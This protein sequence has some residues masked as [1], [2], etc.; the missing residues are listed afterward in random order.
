MSNTA[1]CY[2]CVSRFQSQTPTDEEPLSNQRLSLTEAIEVNRYKVQPKTRKLLNLFQSFGM[3]NITN[4]RTTLIDLTVTTKP[5]LLQGSSVK[6]FSATLRLSQ[7]RPP[8]KVINIRSFKKFQVDQ[9]QVDIS[10]APFHV[11]QIFDH[12]DDVLWAWNSLLKK[13]TI[14]MRLQSV[15]GSVV[16]PHPGWTTTSDGR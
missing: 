13:S 6:A 4:T 11:A 1:S 10:A 9:F 14:P 2:R 12:R 8:P 5:K 3:Q 15:L 16:N 7:K